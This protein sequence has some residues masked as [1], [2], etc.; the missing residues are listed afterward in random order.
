MADPRPGEIVEFGMEFI[1]HSKTYVQ[2]FSPIWEELYSNYRVSPFSLGLNN[3]GELGIGAANNPIRIANSILKDPESHQIVETLLA[4]IMLSCFQARGYI[5]ADPVGREDTRSGKTVSRLIQ[6]GLER[7]GHYQ[8]I[9]EIIKDSLVFGTGIYQIPWELIMRKVLVNTDGVLSSQVRDVV[10]DPGIHPVS[11]WDF[12]PDPAATS[13]KNMIICGKR[14]RM[15]AGRAQAM[16]AQNIFDS[17]IV[18]HAIE[19]SHSYEEERNDE[20][21]QSL[22]G[23]STSDLGYAPDYTMLEG[24]EIWTTDIPW[25]PEDGFTSRVITLFRGVSEAPARNAPTPFTDGELPFGEVKSNPIG[26]RFYGLSPLETNRFLQD[27]TDILLMSR[28]D[29]VIKETKGS[30]KVLNGMVD[31]PNKLRQGLAGEIHYMDD[32]EAILPLEFTHT[33][34][35]AYVESQ[36]QKISMRQASGATDPVQGI[37]SAGAQTATE[38]GIQSQRSLSRIELT[39]NLFER[40]YLSRMGMLLHSRFA[41][42]LDNQGIV[43][44]VGEN[45]PPAM[46]DE[47]QGKF[48]YKFVGSRQSGNQQQK[49]AS[50]REAI[51]VLGSIPFLAAQVNW[52]S[53]VAK[54]FEDGLNIKDFEDF[55]ASPEQLADNIS[56]QQQVGPTNQGSVAGQAAQPQF[57]GRVASNVGGTL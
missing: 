22:D 41:Q 32:L 30:W 10:N 38:I 12:F 51:T 3:T 43:D 5:L 53:L 52:N 54:Y 47:I 6:Y 29:A 50:L 46:R 55:I 4:Q 40:E 39:C 26:S 37:S 57:D 20:V 8:A 36:S 15:T 24:Y 56:L 27:H 2:R 31:N 25:D 16:V 48:N 35:N 19:I 18:E 34:Q 11:L 28:T 44:R 7:P 42:F 23:V 33:L 17:K 45:P 13:I 9:Y 49:A 1:N 14:F 21:I